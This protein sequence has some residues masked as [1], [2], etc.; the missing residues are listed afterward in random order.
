MDAGRVRIFPKVSRKPTYVLPGVPEH[1]RNT[2]KTSQIFTPGNPNAIF[3]EKRAAVLYGLALTWFTKQY[4]AAHLLV[5]P[6]QE[7][8]TTQPLALCTH[9]KKKPCADLVSRT[10][11]N[12]R[13][14]NK[15]GT[16]RTNITRYTVDY[17]Y[18]PSCTSSSDSRHLVSASDHP[19]LQHPALYEWFGHAM[20]MWVD[21]ALI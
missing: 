18:L 14:Q 7:S 9:P 4:T 15:T 12:H 20:S 11:D 5:T 10:T 17:S 2:I 21:G 16:K 13:N 6:I 19:A 1:A 8:I 3:Q